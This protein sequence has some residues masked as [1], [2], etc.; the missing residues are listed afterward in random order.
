MTTMASPSA[1]DREQPVY[2]AALKATAE[3]QQVYSPESWRLAGDAWVLVGISIPEL[4]E[5]AADLARACRANQKAARS[6]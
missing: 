1:E 3:A 4:R 6:I 5:Y 2:Q